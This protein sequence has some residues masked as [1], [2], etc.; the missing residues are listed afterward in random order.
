M[1]HSQHRRYSQATTESDDSYTLNNIDVAHCLHTHMLL[2]RSEI[3]GQRSSTVCDHGC[4]GAAFRL[5]QYVQVL[6]GKI[7]EQNGIIAAQDLAIIEHSESI[8]AL[9]RCLD[10]FTDAR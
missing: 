5:N 1:I 3:L 6:Q 8:K 2:Q 10:N 7:E 9:R 4:T